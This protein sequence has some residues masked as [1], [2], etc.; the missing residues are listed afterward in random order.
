MN[1]SD[2]TYIWSVLPIMLQGLLLTVQVTLTSFGIAL[3]IG[4]PIALG[5]VSGNRW[6]RS[7]ST[8]YIIAVRN[9]PLLAQLYLYFFLLASYGILLPPLV[10]GIFALST[11]FSAYIAEAYRGGYEAVPPGQWE[12]A[13]AIGLGPWDALIRVAGPQAIRPTI[14]VLA[15]IVIQ[16][17]KDSSVL[18]AITLTE[19]FG[20]TAQLAYGSFRYTILYLTLGVLYLAVSYPSGRITVWLERRLGKL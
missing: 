16:M 13:T 17:L 20:A 12:A 8:A 3:V 14:P 9:T 7:V 4:L 1:G 19:V 2:F 11:Q 6:I 10:A 18:S 5:R 15:N